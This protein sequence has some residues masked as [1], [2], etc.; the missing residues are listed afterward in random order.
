MKPL[1]GLRVLDRAKDVLGD[2]RVVERLADD[3]RGD[4]H[5]ERERGVGDDELVAVPAPEAEHL[6]LRI[7]TQQFA[8][9]RHEL[10][11]DR[12]GHVPRRAFEAA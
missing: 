3:L 11:P 7:K 9:L 1:V 5:G 10:D 8:R 12:I 2:L 6:V 4:A